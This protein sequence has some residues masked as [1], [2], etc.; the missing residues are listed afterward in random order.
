MFA[1]SSATRLLGSVGSGGSADSASD[2]T[3]AFSVSESPSG[4]QPA[5]KTVSASAAARR[6]RT[7][8]DDIEDDIIDD[9]KEER[10]GTTTEKA[11]TLPVKTSPVARSMIFVDAPRYTPIESTEPVS[12]DGN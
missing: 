3:V 2:A 10:P 1:G 5:A 12:T 4:V 9:C 6:G 8:E 11:G 7:L